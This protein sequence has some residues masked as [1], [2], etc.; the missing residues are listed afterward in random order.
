MK[1]ILKYRSIDLTR[2]QFEQLKS[3]AVSSKDLKLGHYIKIDNWFYFECSANDLHIISI[4][5][6]YFVGHSPGRNE[7]SDFY[8]SADARHKI[9]ND[10]FLIPVADYVGPLT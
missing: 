7:T 6:D 10:Y 8:F 2:E 1:M 5:E 3:Q 9:D 4:N